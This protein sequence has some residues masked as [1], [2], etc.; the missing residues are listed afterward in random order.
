MAK[1]IA[2]VSQKGGVGKTTTAANLA[3]ALVHEGKR[4]LLL[5]VDPQGSL[6]PSL[7]VEQEQVHWG[8][9][10]LMRDDLPPAHAAI[11][12]SL[13]GLD[14]ISG[15]GI[16]RDELELERL[17]ANH[18]MLL[19]DTVR[20]LAPLYDAVLLDAP[21]TLG[22]LTRATLMAADSFL[23]PVQAEELSYRT[24]ERMLALCDE[25]KAQHN[26][27]LECAGLLITMVDLRT[28]MSAR[29]INQLHENYG[30]KV[31]LSMIPR[32]VALQ[33]MPLRGEPAVLYA[34]KSRGAQAYQEVAAEL[35]AEIDQEAVQELIAEE[36]Q[37][38][39]G[40]AFGDDL[41]GDL[42]NALESFELGEPESTKPAREFDSLNPSLLLTALSADILGDEGR[43]PK[44][45]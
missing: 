12:T 30:D 11:E 38:S 19:R 17:A 44:R 16:D 25:V 40:E 6:L 27:G 14:L 1:V 7:G 33:E 41:V 26:P 45:H 3:A 32:T 39:D 43:G 24:L 4:V 18:P 13:P 2:V 34:P 10:D 36:M 8:L 15:L 35:L 20:K 42:G 23:V 31:L 37:A 21:P 5:E 28:R 22:S 9:L 29:V